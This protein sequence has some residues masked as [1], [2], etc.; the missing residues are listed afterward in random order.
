MNQSL[1]IVPQVVV[2]LVWVGKKMVVLSLEVLKSLRLY[3]L[4]VA[5]F[6]RLTDLY[7]HQFF[8]DTWINCVYQ[9]R[10]KE[11]QDCL[12]LRTTKN[13]VFGVSPRS[14][15]ISRERDIYDDEQREKSKW[16]KLLRKKCVYIDD[17][18][19]SSKSSWTTN[20]V[21]PTH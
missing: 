18:F 8:G 21:K 9:D 13:L 5:S 2:C 1:S 10:N 16:K 6:M 3:H 15:V 4:L 11:N 7:H 19:Q 20:L 17:N 14:H 12:R